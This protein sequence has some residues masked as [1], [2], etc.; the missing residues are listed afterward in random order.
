MSHT[1][2][3][4]ERG[5]THGKR[6]YRL[7]LNVFLSDVRYRHSGESKIKERDNRP[8]LP[9]GAPKAP[10]AV[11]SCHRRPVYKVPDFETVPSRSD[12]KEKIQ[13]STSGGSR[14]KPDS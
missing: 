8:H 7:R 5:R 1:K 2:K 13:I 9:P 6:S 3:K 4:G 14:A 11:R 12:G 10:F